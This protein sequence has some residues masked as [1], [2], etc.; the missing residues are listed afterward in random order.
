MQATGWSRPVADRFAIAR[1]PETAYNRRLLCAAE[2]VD[3]VTLARVTQDL[4]VSAPGL[5]RKPMINASGYFVWLEEGGATP[6]RIVVDASDTAYA[7]AESP[8]PEPPEKSVRI[9]LAPRY[10]Y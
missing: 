6:E 9:E 4:K 7:S 10:G 5:R 8:P 2:M 3:A 1:P